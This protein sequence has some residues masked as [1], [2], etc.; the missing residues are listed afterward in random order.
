MSAFW[1]EIFKKMV[2]EKG[3]A[4]V[5]R[6]LGVSTTTVSLVKSGQYGASTKKIE[7]RVINIY[8]SNGQVMC[9]VLG[10]IDPSRCIDNWE[11]ARK[12]GVSCGNPATMRLYKAC[13]KCT[14]RNS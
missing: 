14:L 7:E 10:E 9:P 13:M 11:L 3:P 12:I 8:G 2:E 4:Q 5:A 6:E 1:L